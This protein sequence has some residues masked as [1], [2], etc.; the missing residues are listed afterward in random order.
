MIFKRG[1]DPDLAAD[2][3]FNQP[4]VSD[5]FSISGF[6]TM[7]YDHEAG[8]YSLRIDYE[9][10]L[11]NLGTREW[12]IKTIKGDDKTRVTILSPKNNEAVG[13]LMTLSGYAVNDFLLVTEVTVTIAP[14]LTPEAPA[15]TKKINTNYA[16]SEMLDLQ[17]A[18]LSTGKYIIQAVAKDESGGM[19]SIAQINFE[20]DNLLPEFL[21]L[22]MHHS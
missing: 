3:I 22:M 8:E 12:P 16:F 14:V 5:P 7:A 15:F 13:K 4:L 6:D 2:I 18:G 21:F 20:Y 9:D 11:G 17:D 1:G 10:V 19:S